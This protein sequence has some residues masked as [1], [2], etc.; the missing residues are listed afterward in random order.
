MTEEKKQI[1]DTTHDY[2]SLIYSHVIKK[3]E[4]K[5]DIYDI[6]KEDFAKIK[7]KLLKIKEVDGEDAYM[8]IGHY[9]Y[10]LND[11]KKNKILIK[12]GIGKILTNRDKLADEFSFY[13]YAG[14][15][16]NFGGDENAILDL[17]VEYIIIYDIIKNG[18]G[19]FYELT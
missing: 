12:Y 14:W 19:G 17:I 4:E 1:I 11:E 13:T 5:K 9:V 2:M 7:E 15:L 8:D 6:V 16:E 3:E 18:E 10:K